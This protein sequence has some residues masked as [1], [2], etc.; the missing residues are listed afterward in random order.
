MGSNVVTK[1]ID[2]EKLRN[3]IGKRD[4]SLRD[5]SRAIGRHPDYIADC[6]RRGLIA[7]SA[8]KAIEYTSNIKYEEYAAPKIE[9]ETPDSN[10]DYYTERF[11]RKRIKDV[12]VSQRVLGEKIGRSDSYISNWLCGNNTLNVGDIA[13]IAK[14]LSLDIKKIPQT[15]IPIIEEKEE[16]NTPVVPE[17]IDTSN[18]ELINAILQID[19]TLNVIAKTIMYFADNQDKERK[20][21]A[22]I[23]NHIKLDKPEKE[24]N[25]G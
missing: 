15:I 8:M 13:G 5:V 20:V 4:L 10:T 3:A 1:P 16:S 24:D 17:T 2:S 22:Y 18:T 11:L 23:A 21:L 7:V 14:I 19:T 25:N 12:C 6:C 9:V